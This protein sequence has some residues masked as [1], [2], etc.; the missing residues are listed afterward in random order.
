MEINVLNFDRA[1][2]NLAAEGDA[3][4]G[5]LTRAYSGITR[6]G[7]AYDYY[8]LD[9][10]SAVANGG[11][12]REIG[13]SFSTS[14]DEIDGMLSAVG[15]MRKAMVEGGAELDAMAGRIRSNTDF[16]QGLPDIAAIDAGAPI[17]TDMTYESALRASLAVQDRLRQTGLNIANA[18]MANALKTFV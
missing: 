7:T 6:S 3:A 16:L 5:I 13:L 8:L 4:D 17:D 18:S 11:G 15:S 10:G 9:A 1:K 2:F 14:R 12:A